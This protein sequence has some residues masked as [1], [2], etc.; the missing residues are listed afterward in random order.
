[1]GQGLS[2]RAKP[3]LVPEPIPEPPVVEKKK[4]F[5]LVE[6]TPGQ[7][8]WGAGGIV[9]AGTA[10]G[11]TMTYR[12]G[13]KSLV[14]EGINPTV[15]V[16]IIPMA[17][18]TLALASIFTAAFGVAGFYSLRSVGL[19]KFDKVDLPSAREAGRLM[20]NPLASM[21]SLIDGEKQKSGESNQAVPK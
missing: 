15:R 17:A 5:E 21:R 4:K 10:A 13:T 18:K 20:R 12:S 3:E 16:K 19:L 2:R 6:V 8:A 7:V 9:A 1:M 14:Q 11:A